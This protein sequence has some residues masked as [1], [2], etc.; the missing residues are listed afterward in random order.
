MPRV[1]TSTLRLVGWH[2][3]PLVL[4]C[5]NWR[6]PVGGLANMVAL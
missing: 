2:F 6:V 4:N 1:I 3:P 5:F